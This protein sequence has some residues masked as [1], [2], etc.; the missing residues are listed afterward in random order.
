MNA[1]LQWLSAG[2]RPPKEVMS[3]ADRHMWALWGQYDRLLLQNELLHRRWFDEK[4]GHES[5]Q[6]C[7]PEK[8]KGAVLQELHDQCGHLSVRKTTDNLRKRFY[9]IGYTADIVL[10]YLSH[11][12]YLRRPLSFS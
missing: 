11:L 2:R 12:S 5:L 8:L 1:V 3:G 4:T 9:W 6:V 7:V 10:S